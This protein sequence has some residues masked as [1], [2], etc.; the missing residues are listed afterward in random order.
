M[1]GTCK[2]CGCGE[3]KTTLNSYDRGKTIIDISQSKADALKFLK[4]EFENNSNNDVN[5]KDLE[6]I[7][8]LSI[9]FKI[10]MIQKLLSKLEKNCWK[11]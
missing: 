3:D 7:M 1:G 5:I 11:I 8:S 2:P 10:S 9:F 6:K 4:N